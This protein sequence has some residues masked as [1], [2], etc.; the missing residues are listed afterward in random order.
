MNQL[1]ECP[2]CTYTSRV[3]AVIREHIQI[4]DGDEGNSKTVQM[5]IAGEVLE[6]VRVGAGL[7]RCPDCYREGNL[8]GM[9]AHY[10][11]AHVDQG[12][13]PSKA[14]RV[15]KADVLED[16][17]P[18]T[19]SKLIKDFFVVKKRKRLAASANQV[20][21]ASSSASSSSSF[22]LQESAAIRKKL[23]ELTLLARGAH[24]CGSSSGVVDLDESSPPSS[25]PVSSSPSSSSLPSPSSSSTLVSDAPP[26]PAQTTSMSAVTLPTP[27]PTTAPTV[28]LALVS[29]NLDTA[30][31]FQGYPS[32]TA[33]FKRLNDVMST[34]IRGCAFHVVM[35]GGQVSD[36][37]ELWRCTAGFLGKNSEFKKRFTLSL[38]AQYAA[39]C[40]DCWTPQ[41][42]AF[43]HGPQRCK[44]VG[45][46][47]WESWWRAV[48]YLVFRTTYLRVRVFLALGLSEGAFSSI[49]VYA[50]WLTSPAQS[51]ADPTRDIRITNLIAVVF[52][53][54]SLR[55]EGK[56]NGAGGG[57]GLDR[58]S[59][60]T[61]TGY[62]KFQDFDLGAALEEDKLGRIGVG[63]EELRLEDEDIE[64][65]EVGS[66]SSF[67][68]DDSSSQDHPFRKSDPLRST[69]QRALSKRRQKT[70]ASRMKRATAASVKDGAA[71][72]NPQA[73][74]TAQDSTPIQ[75]KA[76]DI[77]T[78]GLKKI[79][80]DLGVLTTTGLR[81][82][83]WDRV[84]GPP[85]SEGEDWEGTAGQA[86]CVVH[87]FRGLGYGNGRKQPQDYRVNGEANKKG[88]GFQKSIFNCYAHKTY[89]EYQTT[90]E[91]LIQRH[92]HLRPNLPG[93]PYAALT[94]NAGPQPYSPAHKDS[95]NVVHGWCADTT[96]GQFDPDK[97]GH[98]ALPPLS[99][100]RQ[101]RF[102]RAKLGLR[103]FNTPPVVFFVGGRMAFNP[104]RTSSRRPA[105]RGLGF[106]RQAAYDG[107]RVL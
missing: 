84:G 106:V 35:T 73:I 52:V 79:W 49:D 26:I 62:L 21:A 14:E 32:T 39:C 30:L 59:L 20:P 87:Y 53:Y 13:A 90:N 19:P 78:P 66:L 88:V 67:P 29:L 8:G 91:E 51:L 98:L 58:Y 99:L 2:F 38:H 76:F 45:R 85:G 24:S 1:V 74:R 33:I 36:H 37:Q 11:A 15:R 95:D 31:I 107:G 82:L 86:Q 6:V 10:L 92:P 69:S 96:L 77:S 105:G 70:A 9:W 103:S 16:T 48:P 43:K 47:Q 72:V 63:R 75:L 3:P 61:T 25:P 68:S 102:E 50:D 57:L 94:V 54:F 100:T 81:L 46:T 7:Y 5:L 60:T 64:F 40:F 93:T 71:G 80:R 42:Q 34:V 22:L 55:T 41:D 65:E 44:R 28:S 56:L 27:F 17:G 18:P 104:I 23:R 12:P 83:D 97:G 4:H 101:F 89:L